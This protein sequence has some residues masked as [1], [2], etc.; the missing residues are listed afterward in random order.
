[1]K[2]LKKI[3]FKHLSLNQAELPLQVTHE[4]AGGGRTLPPTNPLNDCKTSKE[5]SN[6]IACMPTQWV[7]GCRGGL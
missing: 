1:M 4:I 5:T 2:P 6:C 7:T 3:A